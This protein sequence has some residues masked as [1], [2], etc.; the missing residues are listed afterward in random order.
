MSFRELLSR[1]ITEESPAYGYTLVIWGSGA[2]LLSSLS[3]LNEIS[4]LSFVL[5]GIIG[6]GA[7]AILA[8]GSLMTRVGIDDKR[9]PAASMIHI[10]GAFGAVALNYVILQQFVGSMETHYISFIVGFTAT[11]AYNILLMVEHL[12]YEDIYEFERRE[13]EE[14][15][16]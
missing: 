5:G 2:L 4:I 13:L 7:L 11:T 8:F 16:A 9:E 3:S 1:N 10:L 14:S 12:L 15:E 6:F